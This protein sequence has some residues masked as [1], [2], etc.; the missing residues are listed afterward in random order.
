MSLSLMK[1]VLWLPLY[2]ASVAINICTFFLL[3]W[4]THESPYLST[5][6]KRSEPFTSSNS[7]P[8]ISRRSTK[9]VD[10]GK[11]APASFKFVSINLSALFRDLWPVGIWR[12]CTI[13]S[14]PSATCRLVEG[15]YLPTSCQQ[16]S[17]N[18]T[19]SSSDSGSNPIRPWDEDIGSPWA[20]TANS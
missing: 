17:A 1:S 15:V 10:V 5:G 3:V 13:H 20:I 4:G 14:D 9:V 18:S 7:N 19:A 6:L 2:N 16:G 12:A 11:G 8:V